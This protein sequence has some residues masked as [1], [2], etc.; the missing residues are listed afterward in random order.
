MKE[1]QSIIALAREKAHEPMALATVV[2]VRGS[3]Y[4]RPG[5]RML[6]TAAG[7]TA[8]MISGGCLEGD[9][10]ERAAKVISTGRPCLL[11]Y[12]SSAPYDIVF[13]LGLGCNGIVQVLV[14]PVSLDDAEGV[15]ALFAACL[16]SRLP[17]RV[18][19]IFDGVDCCGTSLAAHLLLWPDG[20]VASTRLEPA[21]LDPLAALL[22]ETEG[23]KA[24][25][26]PLSLGE[27]QRWSALLETIAPP[28][29]LTLFGAGDDAVPLASL[30]NGL[31]W[32][33]TLVDPRPDFASLERFPLA[34]EVLCLRPGAMPEMAS[35][36]VAMVMTH[37]FIRDK[38]LLRALLPLHLRYLGI[39]GPRSR[40]DRLLADLAEEGMV[41]DS[42]ELACLH[43]PAGLDIGAET[44]EE[45]AVSI[46]AEIQAVLMRRP[47][48]FL[49]LK[50]GGIH[51]EPSTTDGRAARASS[52][53]LAHGGAKS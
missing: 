24:A 18:V 2:K 50:D 8:G 34:D 4:R 37:N 17:G 1:I 29:P 53:L 15:L 52:R 33:V 36:A 7:R 21:W 9:V 48:T 49:R 12:D 44:P 19:S 20:R 10:K 32:R 47:G 41:L 31:G 43:G 45:I 51:D 11:T 28:L 30:A 40:T 3:A 35:E 23:R 13:G 6:V 38:E 25:I 42:A 16:E 27:G 22:E 5:A 46:I 14:E 39:L 26:R